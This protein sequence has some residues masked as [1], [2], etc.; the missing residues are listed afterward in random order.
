MRAQEPFPLL[1]KT[2]LALLVSLGVWVHVM[3]APPSDHRFQVE[4]LAVGMRQPM[5]LEVAPDGR[6]FFNEIEGRLCFVPPGGGKVVEAGR[7]EVFAQQENGLLGFALDPAFARNGWIYLLYSPKDYVGQRLSRFKLT[8]DTLDLKS[9]K[10]LL[11][12]AEQRRECC[13]HA[14]SVEFG[15][16]GCLYISTGD[17]THP[18]GDSEGYAPIDERPDRGPW[19]AQKSSANTHDLRGKILRVRPT[20]EGRLEIPEGNLFPKDGTQ[21]RPEIY[22]MGCR[23]PWRISIDEATGILYWGEV[24]PDA[25]GDGPRGPRGYDEINQA[26][27]AGNFGWP[28]FVGDNYAYAD[29]DFAQRRPGV[30]FDPARPVNVGP[31]NTGRKDLPPA[32]PAFIWWPYGASTQFPALG[33]GGRTACA[34]PVFHYKPSFEKTG[35]FPAHFDNCLLFYDWQR[36]FIKWA[37]LDAQSRLAGIEPFTA[38]VFLSNNKAKPPAEH[39]DAFPIRRPVDSQF[40]PDGRLYMLDYG[41]TWGANPDSRLLRISY[42][43]G[44]LAPLA[45]ASATNAA[46]REPLTVSLDG[47]LS[48][49][50]EGQPLQYEWRLQ[51]GNK[52]FAREPAPQLTLRELGNYVAEL[53]ITSAGGGT[54]VTTLP[55]SVGNAPPQVRFLAPAAGDFYTPGS[56]LNYRIGVSDAEDGSSDQNDELMDARVFVAARWPADD[57]DASADPGMK[58]MRQSDCFNCHATAAKV[59]G[60]PLL[61]IATRYRNQAGALDASVER[62]LKGSTG[63]WGPVPMLPHPGHDAAEVTQMVQ[64]IFSLK[65]DQN[66]LA[67]TR[68]LTARLS[69][70]KDR[71]QPRLLLEATYTDV[72]RAPAGPLTGHAV[73]T[74]RQRR[75]EAEQSDG[76]AGPQTLSADEC[77]NRQ[78]VGAINHGHT[79]RFANLNLA[80]TRGVTFRVA[81]AGAGG[82]IELRAGTADGPV[83]ARVAVQ[84][85]GGWNKWVELSAPLAPPEG[86]TDVFVRFDHPGKGGLMNLDWLNFTQAPPPPQ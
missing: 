24:G 20:P 35:G 33:Q 13:H 10:V 22:V 2:G 79:L 45:R 43:R 73:I 77:S 72:G 36:P 34:G 62:V 69:L 8:G 53:R 15:P 78:F 21:G 50:L 5:E 6:I 46:G 9:E 61:E 51:P 67:Q 41:E 81:S 48:K 12:F 68:G 42:H 29:H 1:M 14:G 32:T 28:Y 18:G 84:P 4:S 58:R 54:A 31:N 75:L 60:P 63:V 74:L 27:R 23:N 55:V 19:D 17:N 25:G 44:P 70:P 59:V 66:G 38:A 47:R 71:V 37:R 80:D 85:T 49:D 30:R 40:G 57:S 76:Q 39:A 83:M 64:W 56:V 52:V 65:A 7:I 86:R 26:R 11:E 82:T 16:D 3:G